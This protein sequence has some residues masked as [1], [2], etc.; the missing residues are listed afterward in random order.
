VLADNVIEWGDFWDTEW[1]GNTGSEKFML[2]L[3]LDFLREY[4]T[5]T[6][7]KETKEHVRLSLEKMAQGGVYDHIGG[8]FFRYSTDPHWKVPHF[9]K[10]LYDNAQMIGLYAKAAAEFDNSNYAKIVSE[11]IAFVNREMKNEAGGYYAALDADTDGEEGKYYVWKE[12]ELKSILKDEFDLFAKYYGITPTNVWEN[13]NYV[14]HTTK[15]IVA[16]AKANHVPLSEMEAKGMQWKRLMLKSRERR[17]RPRVDDKILT[18]WNGLLITGLV[19]AYNAL[20]NEAWLQQAESTFAFLQDKSMAN[21]SLLHSYKE[22]GKPI[23]GFLD[24][25][26]YM[27]QAALKLYSATGNESYL[28]TANAL[29]KTVEE[30]FYD[31]SSGLYRYKKDKELIATILKTNDGVMPSPNAVMAE[32]LLL[33]GHI[34]YDVEKLTKSKTMLSSVLPTIQQNAASYNKWN[35]LLLQLSQPFYEIAVVGA[36]ADSLVKELHAKQLPNVLIVGSKK[37]SELPLFKGRYVAE[38]TFIYVC[39]NSTCKLPVTSVKEAIQQLQNF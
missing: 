30:Q 6:G 2:P 33:L 16:Y 32:N 21:N 27:I 8:G 14:L 15:D 29:A 20:G 11:T 1:G 9:E 3:G 23:D 36:Q 17:T 24:D 34:Y 31:P 5:V 12:D 19:D 28:I 4:N 26:A 35:A 38:E 10:M 7:T 18:S 25:Y 37:E 22:G 39:Q 13:G